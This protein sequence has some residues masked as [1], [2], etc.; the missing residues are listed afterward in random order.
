MD[1]L[2]GWTGLKNGQGMGICVRTV[3]LIYQTDIV[4]QKH[5]VYIVY[6][7][8]TL[9]ITGSSWLVTNNEWV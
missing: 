1:K 5:D 9:K 3:V 2:G 7:S 6:I 4:G 8:T